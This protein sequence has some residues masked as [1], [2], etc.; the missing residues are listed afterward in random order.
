M[1]VEVDAAATPQLALADTDIST[2]TDKIRVKS[3]GKVNAIRARACY[4]V[5]VRSI[6]TLNGIYAK[7]DLTSRVGQNEVSYC[8]SYLLH[9]SI[10]FTTSNG[11]CENQNASRW[12]CTPHMRGTSVFRLILRNDSIPCVFRGFG[13]SAIGALPGRVFS[14]TSL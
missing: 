6:E 9:C 2:G 10:S 14:L 5:I 8:R 3:R 13:T 7:T 11:R 4:R 1:A 12:I